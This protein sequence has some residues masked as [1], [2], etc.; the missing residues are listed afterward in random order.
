M[1]FCRRH[2]T[3]PNCWGDDRVQEANHPPG[4][5]FAYWNGFCN[6]KGGG[7]LKKEKT[8]PFRTFF[9]LFNVKKKKLLLWLLISISLQHNII[10]NLVS[11]FITISQICSIAY[12]SLWCVTEWLLY[13]KDAFSIS[14][15]A[16]MVLQGAMLEAKSTAQNINL[17]IHSLHFIGYNRSC[18][19]SNPIVGCFLLF[20]DQI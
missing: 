13:T 6:A 7:F 10:I 17:T 8:K 4:A 18:D 1:S 16:R 3:G 20:V 11:K 15:E 9:K 14:C 19:F 5:A 2:S 12:I